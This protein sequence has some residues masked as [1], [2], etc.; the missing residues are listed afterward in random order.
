MSDDQGGGMMPQPLDAHRMILEGVGEWKVACTYYMD[1]SQP[2]MECEATD[3]IEAIGPF[4][5]V[6]R[7]ECPLPGG[8]MLLGKA[9][10]GYDVQKQKYIGM[11]IDSFTP[12]MFEYEGDY[13][14]ETKTLEMFGE[15]FFP[16]MQTVCSYRS[17]RIDNGDGSILFEMF[18]TPPGQQE[19]KLFSYLY[20]RA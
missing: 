20:S 4:W 19:W 11:W 3:S 17:V 1:P 9:T 16:A 12:A 2:P 18:L 10:L 15:G 8:Q 5:A 14:P 7:F 13:D 6:S